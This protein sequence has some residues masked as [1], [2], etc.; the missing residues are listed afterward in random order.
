MVVKWPE[1]KLEKLTFVNPSLN[2]GPDSFLLSSNDL[3]C[4]LGLSIFKI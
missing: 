3:A 4:P 2:T 1:Y